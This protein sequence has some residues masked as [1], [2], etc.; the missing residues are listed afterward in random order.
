M[1]TGAAP[2]LEPDGAGGRRLAP[3]ER[4]SLVEELRRAAA[5][6]AVTARTFQRF[7][8]ERGLKLGRDDVHSIAEEVGLRLSA[9][10]IGGMVDQGSRWLTPEELKR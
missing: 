7:V 6:G 10:A 4:K 3:A 8:S 1:A 5:G 9:D 2:P